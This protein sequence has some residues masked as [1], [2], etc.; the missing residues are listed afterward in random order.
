[1]DDNKIKGMS[2]EELKKEAKRLQTMAPLF[3]AVMLI[4]IIVNILSIIKKGFTAAA[5]IPIALLPVFIGSLTNWNKVKKE[6]KLR[7]LS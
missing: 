4:L 5:V 7:N 1:M 6:M 2:D 3:A